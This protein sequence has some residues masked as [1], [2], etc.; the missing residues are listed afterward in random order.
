MTSSENP[1]TSVISAP[2][3]IKCTLPKK[4]CH[5]VQNI[6]FMG[7]YTPPLYLSQDVYCFGTFGHWLDPPMS[8]YREH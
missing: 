5:N 6:H 3:D 2:I 4:K 7:V 1:A 8:K